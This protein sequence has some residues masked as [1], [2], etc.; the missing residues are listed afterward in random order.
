MDRR[1]FLQRMA[2]ATATTAV[3]P[4]G[5][6]QLHATKLKF[7]YAAITWLGDDPTAVTDIARGGWRG[8]QLR[9]AAFD[10]WGQTPD[11][12]KAL[13][14]ERQLTFVA[15]SSGTVS[16]D[17]A[18]EAEMIALHT[19]HAAFVRDAGGKYLQVIDE[20]PIGRAAAPDDYRRMGRLLT[21]IGKRAADLGIG[22]GYHNH[23][24]ALGETPD[25][26]S[27]V[28]DAADPRVVK[29]QLDIAHWT[30]AGGDAVAAVTQY[31]DRLRFVHLK[32]LVRPA[33]GGTATSYR[34]VE[35]GR[36]IVDVR[37]ALA[38][39]QRAAFDGWCIV[40]LDPIREPERT[41][42]ESAEVSKRFLAASGFII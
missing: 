39:L 26:V 41:P 37:G 40:E 23:M 7:G 19:R 32:D 24:G 36:G 6:T 10:R 1:D 14:A 20:R 25:E 5:R 34:F 38:A 22:L 2:M 8:I 11:V 18:R 17:P 29:L 9:T 27:R 30:A 21:E 16:N 12:L 33:P 28:L 13:L 35:L 15:L 4:F 3:A 31:A 42:A